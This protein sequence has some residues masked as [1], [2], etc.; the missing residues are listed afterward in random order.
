MLQI[1][2]TALYIVGFICVAIGLGAIYAS[3]K[4]WLK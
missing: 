1:N 4:G 2:A 3:K